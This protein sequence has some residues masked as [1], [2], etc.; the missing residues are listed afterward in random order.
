LGLDRHPFPVAPDDAH[1]Y[2]SSFIEQV[3]AEVVHG[4]DTRK[5]FMVISGDVGLGK[6]TVTR[7]ILHLLEEKQ[8]NT[9]LVFHTALKDVALL[10]EI[11]RDFGLVDSSAPPQS[12]TLGDELQRLNTFLSAQYQQ[13]KNC[14]IIIDDAQNLDRASLELVRMISNLETDSQKIVQIL[15]VGQP[16]LMAK[17]GT[18]ELRQLKS[19]IF[20]HKAM[21]PLNVD[22]LRTYVV[23]KLSQAGN[24]GRIT[25]TR[26]GFQA[27][28][29]G[30]GGNFR[31]LNMLMDRCLYVLCH[32]GGRCIDRRQ[33]RMAQSDLP[34]KEQPARKRLPAL[35]WSFGLPVMMILA[36]WAIHFQISRGATA[37]PARPPMNASPSPMDS[38]RPAGHPTGAAEAS[39]AAGPVDPAV[40]AFLGSHQLGN[41][42]ADFERARVQGQL[43]P[44]AGKVLREHGLQLVQLPSLSDGVRRQYGALALPSP[45]GK[46]V[47]WM[48]LWRPRVAI[49][50]FYYGYQG[51]E[52]AVL[53]QWLTKTSDYTRRIDG[54]V[55]PH[56]MKAL[57]AFQTRSGLPVTGW[58]DPATLF[59]LCQQEGAPNV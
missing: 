56:L 1:F 41:E 55:G 30:S 52:I 14:A 31:Q 50:R 44:W 45:D 24:Q 13:G 38:N 7:Q 54:Q 59:T 51:A 6:T 4:I 9:S 33:V 46:A 48:L 12:L 57:L 35:A 19:R 42:A 26:Q 58:P 5:G 10:R 21:R 27:L 11:N 8:V 39:V 18:S 40:A 16:E 37:A 28:Y 15:L 25:L 3:V 47:V 34:S 53:Q 32:E 22:E 2:T 36:A 23:F 17:L 49:P 20:L 29:R 43:E